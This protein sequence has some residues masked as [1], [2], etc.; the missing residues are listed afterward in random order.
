MVAAMSG[1]FIH[2]GKQHTGDD[3]GQVYAYQPGHLLGTKVGRPR[4]LVHK[5]LE[6][7]NRGNRHN[8]ADQLEF[9]AG[10]I[11]LAHP[12]RAVFAIGRVYA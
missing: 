6:Q 4:A 12:F 5:G 3:K 1:N 11:D 10:V 9:K 7:I 2:P 8:R